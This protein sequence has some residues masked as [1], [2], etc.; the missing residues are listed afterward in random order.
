[1]INTKTTVAALGSEKGIASQ[2]PVEQLSWGF[3]YERKEFGEGY[4][5]VSKNG[6]ASKWMVYNGKPY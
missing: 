5:G 1:M 2:H 6:G 4:L 3:K